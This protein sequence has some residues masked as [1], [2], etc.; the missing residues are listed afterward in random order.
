MP[1]D[2][3]KR[4]HRRHAPHALLED[5]SLALSAALHLLPGA[6]ILAAFVWIGLPVS[7]AMGYPALFGLLVGSM[8]VLLVWELGLLLYLGRV[9]NG[10][11]SL[12]GV[13]Q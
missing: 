11:W 7:E 1:T 10:S 13:V 9:G 5:H 8:P 12:D 3:V 4:D 6:M 2:A